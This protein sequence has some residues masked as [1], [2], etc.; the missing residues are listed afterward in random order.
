MG[1][2]L[3]LLGDLVADTYCHVHDEMEF[4][5]RKPYLICFEC[6]HVYNTTTDLEEDYV[7]NA[8]DKER[9]ANQ[10]ANEIF[11]CPN[12]LHDF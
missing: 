10:R 12:C 8:P 6:G 5:V 2:F 11:F 4:R 1:N 9:A 7:L 3:V